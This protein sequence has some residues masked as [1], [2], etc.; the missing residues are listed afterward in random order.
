MGVTNAKAGMKLNGIIESYIAGSGGLDAGDFTEYVNGTYGTDTAINTD[1]HTGDYMS[2]VALDSTHVFI[3]HSYP[4]SYYL[5]GI[6]CTVDGT[7]I[8]AGTN[9]VINSNSY[10]GHYSISTVVLDSTHVFIAYG[11]SS[12]IHDV[13]CTVNGTTITVGVDTTINTAIDNSIHSISAVALDSTHVFIAHI[14]DSSNK[15]L[16]GVVCTI[17]GTTITAGTDTAINSNSYSGSVISA[18]ALDSTHVFIAH[19][20]SA[21]HCLYG[22][23]C[24]V[25][26]TTITPG[27][28]YLISNST[29]SSSVISAVALNASNAVVYHTTSSSSYT[30]VYNNIGIN[31]TTITAGTNTTLVN[32]GDAA[33]VIFATNVDS[34]GTIFIAHSYSTTSGYSLYAIVRSHD[35]AVTFSSSSD[36]IL[37]VSKQTKNEGEAVDIIVPNV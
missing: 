37:G 14:Y 2:A 30:L 22:I 16:Y 17:S 11:Y 21:L 18:V 10:S 12:N 31:G 15:Y 5:Y 6:V 7:T 25:D 1:I 23:V 13:V 36:T 27:S 28:N 29:Q 9:T 34:F 20:Y 19:S 26:G 4:D 3:A 32:N 24:T 33:R 8:T 35:S